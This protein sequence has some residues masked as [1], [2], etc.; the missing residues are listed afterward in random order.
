ME[1]LSLSNSLV[2]KDIYKVSDINNIC[3]LV[4]N[5]DLL[6]KSNLES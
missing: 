5:M 1:L 6:D 4:D 2:H 3:V